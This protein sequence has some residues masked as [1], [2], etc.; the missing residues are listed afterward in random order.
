MTAPLP[1]DVSAELSKL[2]SGGPLYATQFVDLLLAAARDAGASDVHLHPQVGRTTASSYEVRWRIDGV[3]QP[4]GEFPRGSAADIVARLKVL[5]GL[6]TYRTDVPQEGRIRGEVA[7]ASVEMRVSTFPTLHGERAVVRLFAGQSQFLYPQDLGLPPEIERALL[8]LLGE[9]SGAVLITGPAGSGKTTTAYACVREVVRAAE[10]GRSVVSLEDPIE[11]AL[12]GVSQSQVQPAAGFDL[13]IGLRSLMRQ[14]PEVILVGEIRDRP[15]A[16]TVFQAALTGHLVLST[17]HAGSAAGGISRLIDMGIEPY[18]LRS[19][20]RAM[21]H[22]RLVRRAC[23]CAGAGCPECRHTGYRG[24][25]VLA[26]ILPPLVGELGEAV[27]ARRDSVELARLATAA[28]MTTI[29]QR[30]QAAVE[31]GATDPAEVRRVLGFS[32]AGASGAC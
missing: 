15:T 24:R 23:S 28:G 13:A 18:L 16:E 14:D 4:L 12:Q 22:Q 30:A 6:L 27:L 3:L 29:F 19:G 32:D 31:A 5:A 17:F 7:P 26:E 25:L 8:Q 9:T 21:L 2:D 1:N 10:G 11:M 20:V